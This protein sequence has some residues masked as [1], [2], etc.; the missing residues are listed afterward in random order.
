MTSLVVVGLVRSYSMYHFYYISRN[1]STG[2]AVRL[3]L[4]IKKMLYKPI[5]HGTTHISTELYRILLGKYYLYFIVLATNC[6]R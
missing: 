3:T 1:C 6:K 4:F 5:S 2:S